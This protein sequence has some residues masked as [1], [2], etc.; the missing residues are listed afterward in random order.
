MVSMCKNIVYCK[1]F[2]DLADYCRFSLSHNEIQ[3][4]FSK[5]FEITTDVQLVGKL[6]LPCCV[7][8]SSNNRSLFKCKLFWKGTLLTNGSNVGMVLLGSFC[9]PTFCFV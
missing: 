8:F 2:T 4:F 3:A 9:L 6:F 5:L 7:Y 1:Q